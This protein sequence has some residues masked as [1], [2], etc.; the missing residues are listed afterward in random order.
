MNNR[1]LNLILLAL[2]IPVFSACGKKGPLIAP[3]KK[4]PQAAQAVEVHQRGSKAVLTWRNPMTYIDGSPL[5]RLNKIEIYTAESL[6]EESPSG[7]PDAVFRDKARLLETILKDAMDECAY[8]ENPSLQHFEYSFEPS[9]INK[10][11]LA[12]GIKA[13]DQRGKESEFSSLVS[14][15]PATVSRPPRVLQARTESAGVILTWKTPEENIDGTTPALV[16][17]YN[18]YK[19]TAEESM[20][21]LNRI[22]VPDTEFRDTDIEWERTY[23]YWVRAAVSE[24]SLVPESEDSKS[25]TVS[26]RD[27]FPP[28][29]PEGLTAI[30]GNDFVAL[31]WRAIRG[32]GLQGYRVWRREKGAEPFKV[33]TPEPIRETSYMD[34][35]A[36]SGIEYQY[37]VTAVDTA[38]NES[39]RSEAVAATVRK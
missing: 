20:E 28:D 38:G 6:I 25:V 24:S 30:A 1:C 37:R 17:G 34:R 32:S 7:I 13:F 29:P 35:T 5:E 8:P 26:P 27:I 21:R 12:F 15:T 23:T 10:T 9:D 2:L 11:V 31:S 19:K 39:G 18:I 16:Q 22:P 3:V 33:L 36:E 4:V 14:L